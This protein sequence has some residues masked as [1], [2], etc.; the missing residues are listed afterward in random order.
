V[1]W[2]IVIDS[3]WYRNSSLRFWNNSFMTGKRDHHWLLNYGCSRPSKCAVVSNCTCNYRAG[4]ASSWEP[5]SGMRSSSGTRE[6]IKDEAARIES[7]Q[8]AWPWEENQWNVIY[9][10]LCRQWL[11]FLIA[12]T[13]TGESAKKIDGG[14][15]ERKIAATF[16]RVY[17]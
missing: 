7:E 10:V 13:A 6:D 12:T 1:P 5:L 2:Q 11:S 8:A 3:I 14:E 16:A 17:F 9:V 4:S 15:D